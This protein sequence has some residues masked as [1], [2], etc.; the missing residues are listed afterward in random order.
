[1]KNRWG[2][3]ITVTLLGISLVA[4]GCSD[5]VEIDD[6][7]AE[8]Q[9]NNGAGGAVDLPPS[10]APTGGA[11]GAEDEPEPCP[12]VAARLEPVL[13]DALPPALPGDLIIGARTPT[14][15]RWVGITGEPALRPDSIINAG[16]I[17]EML[18][19]AAVMRLVDDET[20][21]LEDSLDRWV[22]TPIAEASSITLRMLLNHTSGLDNHFTSPTM[23]AALQ[24]DQTQVFTPQ[25][26]VQYASEQ[27]LLAPPGEGFSREFINTVLL[28]LVLEGATDQ[29]AAAAIRSLVLT[30]LGLPNLGLGGEEVPI[31]SLAAGFDEAGQ[32]F[33]RIL[34]PSAWWVS[35]SYYGTVGDVVTVT[36]GILRRDLLSAASREALTAMTVPTGFPGEGYGLG[37]I[38]DT[39]TVQMIGQAGAVPG[40]E[41]RAFFAPAL[42][43]VVVVLAN[44]MDAATFGPL[45]DSF[46]A[47]AALN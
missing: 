22:T 32:D 41:I 31:A 21:S 25:Q 29:S 45:L 1:M 42:D 43:S 34:H 23:I 36:D 17:S 5:E 19:A 35:A 15:E 8:T 4:L 46:E 14:C 24:A 33:S 2:F 18:V 6:G 3:A 38:E 9:G 20:L 7:P 44:N 27:P 40:F 28:G 13:A 26:L 11:G 30:P 47:L 12:D 16:V 37:V 39:E 10:S